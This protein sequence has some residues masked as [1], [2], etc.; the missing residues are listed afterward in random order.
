M[1]EIWVTIKETD[2]YQISNLGRLRHSKT[3]YIRMPFYN[4]MH[5]Y[6]QHSILINGEDKLLKIHR[7]V[8]QAFIPNPENKPTVNHINCIKTDNRV[9]NLEWATMR[10]QNLHLLSRGL[11]QPYQ[12]KPVMDITTGIVFDSILDAAKSKNMKRNTLQSN[13]TGKVNKTD[14]ILV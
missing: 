11:R 8:A 5:K 14:F 2:N 7:L 9:E 6:E 3:L 10:E 1:T 13:L 4:K 12:S